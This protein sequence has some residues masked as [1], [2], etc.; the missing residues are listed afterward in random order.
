M[1]RSDSLEEL[2]EIARL[3]EVDKDKFYEV[4]ETDKSIKK[5]LL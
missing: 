5:F 3:K 1:D 2:L 4:I